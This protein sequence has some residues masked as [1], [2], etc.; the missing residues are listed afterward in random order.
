MTAFDWP[1]AVDCP[2]RGTT[3]HCFAAHRP[4]SRGLADQIIA[5]LAD[6]RVAWIK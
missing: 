6:T 3:M 2:I 4:D 1:G 5:G